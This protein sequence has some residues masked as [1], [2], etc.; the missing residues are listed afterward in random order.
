[1]TRLAWNADGQRYFEAGVDHG[2]LYV[3]GLGV[4]WNGLI[5]VSETIDGGSIRPFYIDGVKY[6]D[7]RQSEEF[8]AELTAYT[9]PDEFQACE[10]VL[11][12]RM[13]LYSTMQRKKDF[14]LCYRTSVGNDIEGV[15]H[16]FKLHLI[17]N[18]KTS[19]SDR[20]FESIGEDVEP[21]NFRW[22]IVA[23]PEV[24]AGLKPTPNFVIDSR[25]IPPDLLMD[26][27]DVLYGTSTTPA[28]L[29][30]VGE[31]LS[32]FNNYQAVGFDAG[33]LTEEYFAT[34][35]AGR[36]GDPYTSTIDGGEL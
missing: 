24:F 23:R 16:A 30:S 1:M 8:R 29:P 15:G 9:Y 13:G 22:N 20:D 19:P 36:V 27:L 34:F 7:L 17:Y 18:C 12:V 10:G 6:K 5:S 3:D 11:P 26:I 14:G 21:F 33:H 32:I 28:R 2:V 31:L 35:D 4:P 25:E